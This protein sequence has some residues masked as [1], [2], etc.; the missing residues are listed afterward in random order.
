MGFYFRKSL[1]FGPIRFN[2]SK[3]GIG[4]SAGIKG[5][6][7]STG[8]RGTYVHAGRNGFYY[9]QRIGG[10]SVHTP[11]QGADPRQAQGQSFIPQ[12][13]PTAFVVE[14]ADV[15]RLVETSNVELLNQIN[16]NAKQMRFAP[17][18][19]LGTVALSALTF[20]FVLGLGAPFADHFLKDRDSAINIASIAAVVTTS[21]PLILGMVFS[22]R[23]HKGD[24]LKRTTP[25][26]YELEQEALDKFSAI[27]QACD[28]L[29]GSARVWR[30]ET[31]QPTW[32]WKRNAGASAII[33]RQPISIV[34]RQPPYIATNVD[35]RS[36]KLNDMDL[37]FM[38]DCL[39]VRQNGRYGAVSYSS[40]HLEFS[41]TRFIEEQGVPPDAHIVDYTWRFV[42]KKGGP[43]R[44]F[45]NNR[46]L[47]IAQYGFIQLQSQTGMNIHLNASNVE[48]SAYFVNSLNRAIHGPQAE[49]TT[50]K[51]SRRTNQN[52]QRPSQDR[53]PV[54]E[55]ISSAYKIL[56]VEVGS[57]KDQIVTA[58]RQMAK[59]YHPDRVANLAPEFIELAEE[60]MKEINAAYELLKR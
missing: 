56:G 32:D 11:Q 27:Q 42:N 12:P 38:P 6:R 28:A 39:F 4:V 52:R 35:V 20:A 10:S 55:K 54:D 1:R 5:A 24:E 57:P 59:M 2:F 29:S 14:T 34:S 45:N 9:S 44:R 26:F 40:F 53:P 16:S 31:N 60:R 33:T 43:D 36:I 25:L 58:Y 37:F 23:V 13:L 41:A 50:Y 15:S 46:Q 21:L 51:E 19:V 48:R 30:V 49:S 18:A 8:P 22:W 7:I 17:F 3:S 47:P